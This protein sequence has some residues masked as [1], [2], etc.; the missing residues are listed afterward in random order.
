MI[1]AAAATSFPQVV[2]LSSNNIPTQAQQDVA[3]IIVNASAELTLNTT[4]VPVAGACGVLGS[5]AP[6]A[7]VATGGAG[8][9]CGSP[10]ENSVFPGAFTAQSD[11]T[12]IANANIDLQLDIQVNGIPIGASV[13]M[14]DNLVA[15]GV[16]N[17]IVLDL[18]AST[19]AVE[20]AFTFSSTVT[21]VTLI[22][23]AAEGGIGAGV[24]NGIGTQDI[25]NL[26]FAVAA[27]AAGGP[28][29]TAA[30]IT[31]S[32]NISP[33]QAATTG[34]SFPRY[35]LATVGPTTLAT[36]TPAISTLLFPA[37]R[38]I[39]GG[40]VVDTG[41]IISNTSTDSVGSVVA[42]S[43]TLIF[44]VFANNAAPVIAAYTTVGGD[45]GSG[46]DA[47]GTVV[48][49]GGYVV[50][51]SEILAA[52]GITGDF[53]GYVIVR[54]NFTNAHAIAFQFTNTNL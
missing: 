39:G 16:G 31:W 17:L 30:V 25:V 35:Q 34:T 54:C 24:T 1:D 44:D 20:T 50:L 6:V 26:A 28:Y 12:A 36:F 18:D 41:F 21:S 37:T 32:A 33:V 22:A 51:F 47:T 43:G 29:S 27:P 10:E 9:V 40:A 45:P 48:A 19:G 52:A 3:T 15:N 38:V 2:R 14:T 4:T 7:I 53:D 23:S 46:T 49:G 8:V 13:V 5:F 11:G 42:N